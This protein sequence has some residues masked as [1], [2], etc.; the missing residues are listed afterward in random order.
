MDRPADLRRP[1]EGVVIASG[2]VGGAPVRDAA[3]QGWINVLGVRVSALDLP[4]AVARIEAGIEAGERGYVCVTGAHGIVE[5]Q[6]DPALRAV[7]NRAKLVTPDGMPLVWLLRWGG[8]RWS[9]RV[10]GPDLMLAVFDAGRRR[11]RRHF[12][13]GSTPDT[14][15]RLS[16]NLLRRFPD[17]EIVGS[18]S[19]PFRSLEPAEE[20]GI[21]ATINASG[22][23]IVWVGL[24]TP[25]QELWMA[26]MRDRLTAPVL[27]GVGAA[28]DFHAG[29]KRQAPGLVQR[30]G[31][32]WA[33]R[34]AT[35]PR[36]LW[37][38]YAVVV[39]TF[40]LLVAAQLLGRQMPI[41]HRE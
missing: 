6:S 5:C 13:Y 4:T 39:P 12:L 23:D 34:L 14:L 3:A 40:T 35:E 41:A 8:Y 1:S 32:E 37:K 28:F 30:S 11:R 27:I 38:R 20:A 25:R 31:L 7:H 16:T 24:S 10:Y 26:G 2:E 18:F 29:L 19:P 22:A 36:R 9:G 17:A 33:F 15:D 21:A